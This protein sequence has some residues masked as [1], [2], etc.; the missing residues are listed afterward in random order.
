MGKEGGVGREEEADE[1]LLRVGPSS[2][3]KTTRSPLV[4]WETVNTKNTP[5]G[6]GSNVAETVLEVI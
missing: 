6:A 3:M 4:M 2:K 1:D 5:T